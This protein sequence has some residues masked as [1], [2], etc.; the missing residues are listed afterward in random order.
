MLVSQLLEFYNGLLS[1]IIM[2]YIIFRLNKDLKRAPVL[3]YVCS[4]FIIAVLF[5][6][7]YNL[8]DINVAVRITV[9]VLAIVFTIMF[10]LKYS[11]YY[12]LITSVFGS[13]LLGFGDVFVA[14]VYA[15][16]LNLNG[17][18][19]RSSFLH[20]TIGSILM[21]LFI[22]GV[23]YFIADNYM[24]ARRRIYNKYNKLT[25]FFSINLVVVFVML[26]FVISIMKYYF[27][28]QIIKS[29]SQSVY[30]SIILIVAVLL[31][32][33]IGTLY[34]INNFIFNKVR[35]ERLSR[36]HIMDVMTDTLSR[37][38][39]LK[40]IE[41]QLDVCKRYNE[42]LV[43][44]Y[45]DINDLKLINDML[46]HREGDL[47]IKTIVS[48]IKENIRETDVVSRL[49]G[50]EFVIVF[51]GCNVDYAKKVLERIADSLKL[52]K[53]RK[54]EYTMSISYGFSQYNGETDI[55]VE[56]LLEKADHQMY[57]NKRATKAMA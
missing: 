17:N 47:L 7:N 45:I 37:G 18:T 14:L 43:I 51:P 48:T 10:F 53:P 32:S 23:L 11:C 42:E 46:G 56:G 39:G 15:Y 50:D 27:D 4:T 33:I 1:A 30:F 20:I 21:F 24:K 28:S 44:C 36:H 13:L 16:P 52:V 54:N 5:F 49:G 40:F 55:T 9:C 26:L 19:F 35:Y 29:N 2:C 6:V 34:I 31:S 8:S 12:A 22:F 25:L 57:Q 3:N 41:E 38:S